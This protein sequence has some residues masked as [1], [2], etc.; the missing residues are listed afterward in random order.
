MSSLD[1]TGFRLIIAPYHD[2]N[3]QVASP[4]YLAPGH[5]IIV[6]RR[7]L[8]GGLLD[9]LRLGDRHLDQ[10]Q[11]VDHFRMAGED[12][13]F[14]CLDTEGDFEALRISRLE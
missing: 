7:R 8:S 11:Q 1:Q 12:V 13:P 6:V 9:Y 5:A 14:P 4:E 3:K 2:R 10:I